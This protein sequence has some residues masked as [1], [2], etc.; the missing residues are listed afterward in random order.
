MAGAFALDD[1]YAQ[2][3]VS[4]LHARMQMQIET[5]A[6]K[7]GI[8]KEALVLDGSD[9]QLEVEQKLAAINGGTMVGPVALDD[10]DVQLDGTGLDTGM[11]LT[12]AIGDGEAQMD[13]DGLY[14]YSDDYFGSAAL[15]QGR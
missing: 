14:A 6:N 9:V 15:P 2:L 8:M 12:L 10:G 7:T 4:G 13:D 1:G 5:E 11:Q 3:D